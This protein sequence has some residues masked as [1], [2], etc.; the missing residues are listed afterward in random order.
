MKFD[1]IFDQERVFSSKPVRYN[2]RRPADKNA[3]RRLSIREAWLTAEE[4][5]EEKRYDPINSRKLSDKIDR[6][7]IQ[8]K[9]AVYDH[10][11]FHI[12]A[13]LLI[14]LR[15]PHGK[16]H[17]TRTVLIVNTYNT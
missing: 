13:S 4:G 2:A 17:G 8:R 9:N 11:I 5:E 3:W 10:K 6:E 1:D 14:L 12:P 15:P 16:L 7:E